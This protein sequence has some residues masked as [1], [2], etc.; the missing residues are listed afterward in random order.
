MKQWSINIP[1]NYLDSFMYMGIL[2]LFDFDGKIN[3]FNFENM[4]NKRLDLEN[5]QNKKQEF[6][7]IFSRQCEK[8]RKSKQYNKNLEIDSNFLEQFRTDEFDIGE[9]V[10]DVNITS[11]NVY[12]SSSKGVQKK[13]FFADEH[14][15]ET[16]GKFNKEKKG[17]VDLFLDTKVYSIASSAGRTVLCCGDE[18]AIYGLEQNSKFTYIKEKD[19][20][21]C[22]GYAV[23][24]NNVYELEI[25]Q[26]ILNSDVMD[27][28][29]KNTSY[30]IEGGYFCYQKK[31]VENFSIPKLNQ[32]EINF[33]KN[34]N[35]ESLNKF[36]WTKYN[37]K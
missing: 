35:I 21:F 33:I 2:F 32:E 19:S 6:Q 10:T 24:E 31:Y 1:G 37:L 36:L 27:Y 23:F 16:Y 4:L 3:V 9:W 13:R 7:S 18:G 12:F 11:K 22:N 14:T 30:S 26:K 17:K 5:D 34:C 20:L 29:I 15:P 28:Y 8:N 25:I